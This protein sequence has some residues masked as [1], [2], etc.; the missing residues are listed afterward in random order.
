VGLAGEGPVPSASRIEKGDVLLV[1]GPIGD[2]GT[3]ILGA[4]GNLGLSSS[5][6]SDSAALTGLVAT[7][8]GV[9]PDIHAMRDLTR[10]GLSAA[11]NELARGARLGMVVE[12]SR[13]PVQPEVAAACEVLGLDPMDVANEGKLVA[14]VP[15]DWADAVLEAMR[16]HPLGGAAARIGTAVEEHPGTVVGKT[17]IGGERVIDVPAGELLP[18]IC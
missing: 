9:C 6:R 7:A 5:V 2:H 15:E 14:A 11:L 16:R 3:A 18:R 8:M 4:R 1:N 12:E 17:P 10:G 13:V